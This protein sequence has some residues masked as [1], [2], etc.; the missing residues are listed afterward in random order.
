MYQ[1]RV[2]HLEGKM[3]YELTSCERT[4]ILQAKL[5]QKAKQESEYKFYVLYDKIFLP[6]ILEE[7]WREVKRNGGG[8]GVDGVSIKEIEQG[9]VDAYLKEL[10]EDLRKR[11]YKPQAVKRVWIPK[12]NGGERPLGIPTVR[13]RIAQ[14]ACKLVLEPIFEADFQSCS[15]GFRPGHSAADAIRE[16]KSNLQAG[17]TDI[18]DADLSKYFDTIPHDKLMIVLKLRIADPRVLYLIKLWLKSPIDDKGKLSGGKSNQ[19]GVPQGGVISPLL[20]NIY[21]NLIDRIINRADSIF[22]KY[23]IKIIRY[24]DDFVLMGNL[25]VTGA[26]EKLKELLTR[27]GL[28]LNED[29]TKQINATESSFDFLGFTFRYDKD[30]HGRNQSYLNIFPSDKSV[31]KLKEKIGNYL[32]KIGNCKPKTISMGLNRILCG[33]FN[34]YTIPQVTYTKHV[35]RKIRHYLSEKLS[36]YYKRKSQR[37]SRLYRQGAYEILI[38]K[39]GLV[40]VITYKL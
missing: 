18:Y 21:M 22:S 9:D 40:D 33:S 25:L 30:L 3:R 13:D 34:Y 28:T 11:T 7:A 39:Y 36:R 35:R 23:G 16:I 37:K 1:E 12:P 31:S 17:K 32:D 5:Y 4:W 2:K 38:Q 14:A 27:M 26:I 19:Q 8:T 10:G 6:Y 15:H 24:A 20:A 29:K